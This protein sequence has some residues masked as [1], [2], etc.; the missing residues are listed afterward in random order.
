MAWRLVDRISGVRSRWRSLRRRSEH[1]RICQL[2]ISCRGEAGWSAGWR[3]WDVV[4]PGG[5]RGAAAS[6]GSP[7]TTP[8]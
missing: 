8:R 7:T 1:R 6:G 2:G 5:L 3:Y 4:Q